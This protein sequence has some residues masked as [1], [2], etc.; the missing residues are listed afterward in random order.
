MGAGSAG[1]GEESAGA[2][3][4]AAALGRGAAGA[5]KETVAEAVKEEVSVKAEH[6]V[7]ALDD[8]GNVVVIDL[9]DL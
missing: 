8:D 1:R 4:P 9:R 6:F 7:D 5:A 2:G 3:A